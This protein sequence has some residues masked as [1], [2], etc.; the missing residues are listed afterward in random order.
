MKYAKIVREEVTKFKEENYPNA[1]RITKDVLNYA[2]HY[3]ENLHIEAVLNYLNNVAANALL[4]KRQ[5][6]KRL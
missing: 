4:L 3:G 1:T 2:N 5:I 6:E